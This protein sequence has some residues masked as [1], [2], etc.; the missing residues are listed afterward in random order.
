M[1]TCFEVLPLDDLFKISVF[2]VVVL[3]ELLFYIV[4]ITQLDLGLL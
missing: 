2:F 1:N 4:A 3:S